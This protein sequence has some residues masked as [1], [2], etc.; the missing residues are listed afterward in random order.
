MKIL[1]ADKISPIG[2]E[3]LKQQPGFE[4]VV[5][6]DAIA[7]WKAAP[8][9]VKSLI[10]DVDGVAVRSETKI[11]S[12]IIAAAPKLKVVGRAGVGVDN[13]DIEAATERGII[14]MNTPG[15][16]TI[17]TAELTFTHMLSGTRPIAQ[18]CASMKAGRWDRKLYSGYEL[19]GKTLG[20]CGLGRIGAEVAKRAIAFNMT[21]L[22]FDPYLTQSRADA[23][24][25]K[26]VELDEVFTQSDY[27]TVHMPLT[28]DTKHMIDEA[29]FAKMKD[30]VRV[31]NVARGGIIKESALIEAVKSGKVAAAGL[32]VYEG[33]PLAEDSELRSLDKVVLTPHLGA[34]TKEAQESVGVEIAHQIA[35]ALSGGMVRNAINMPSVDAK[36][37]EVLKPYL[38]LGQALG[39]FVQQLAPPEVLKLRVTYTGKMN[40]LDTLPLDRA[41][42]RGFLAKISDHVNDVNVPKKLKELGIELETIKSNQEAEYTELVEVQAVCADG[43]TRTA[44]GTLIGKS[45]R[46]VAID[47]HRV[48][49][50][51]K[52]ILLVFK[53]KD[54]PGIVGFLGTELGKDGVN[55]ANMSMS[56]DS[57]EGWAISVFELDSVPSEKAQAE[58]IKHEAILKF[59]IIEL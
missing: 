55:I 3:F 42:L 10:G 11:S 32:D 41:V 46:I 53:N 4:V 25:I 48:E 52:G 29:A 12:E 54:V 49:V 31:F 51:T 20:V 59:R 58:I 36:S 39:S 9:Q 45:P 27:I 6:W 56:R 7:D 8:E 37:L 15:G 21:V 16:N 18:A 57:G 22:A 14:V 19:N 43:K 17:A 35:E 24:G 13:I 5:A 28:A 50:N 2:I 38:D 33:E 40:S 34:S 26:K 44:S 1:V 30:G 47:G 23:L